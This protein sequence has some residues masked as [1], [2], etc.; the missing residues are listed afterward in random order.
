MHQHCYRHDLGDNLV[1]GRILV[2]AWIDTHRHT[3]SLDRF[4]SIVLLV[5]PP[6]RNFL[7]LLLQGLLFVLREFQILQP[8]LV[9]G[10]GQ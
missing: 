10:L 8:F 2:F 3:G 6:F 7:Q 5:L 9:L 4:D 1:S